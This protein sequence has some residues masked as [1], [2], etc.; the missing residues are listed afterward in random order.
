MNFRKLRVYQLAIEVL[1]VLIRVAKSLPRGYASVADEVRRAALSI[2]RNIAEGSGKRTP[3]NQQR[4]YGDARG[5]AMECA[6]IL[7]GCVALDLVSWEG[8]VS[9][10]NDKLV[11][12]VRM[13]SKMCFD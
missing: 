8:D 5:S 9:E 10:A 2:S 1:P 4:Y 3:K 12:I 6:A 13:L 7:D 11:E